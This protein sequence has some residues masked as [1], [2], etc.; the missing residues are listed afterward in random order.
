MQGAFF[1]RI[2]NKGGKPMTIIKLVTNDQQLTA[3]QKPKLASGDVESVK[4]QVEFDVFWDDFIAR[5]AVFHTAK[6]MTVYEALLTNNECI[7]PHEV[8]TE[9]GTLFIGIRGIASDGGAVKT[10][11]LIKYTITQGAEAGETTAEPTPDMYQQ[12][13]QAMDEKLDP[14]LENYRKYLNAKLEQQNRQVEAIIDEF[15]SDTIGTI[16]RHDSE[17]GRLFEGSKVVFSS[18]NGDGKCGESNP[19]VLQFESK[20]L[21]IAYEAGGSGYVILFRGKTGA[22][23]SNGYTAGVSVTWGDEGSVSIYSTI[24]AA[25]QLNNN[26]ENYYFAILEQERGEVE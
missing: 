5:S 22:N 9:P 21:V 3:S 23:G 19:T 26:G 15:S 13:L 7:I 4:V 1:M 17:I 6:H 24:G 20:P 2:N 25:Q 18:R 12:Y 14:Y 16:E 11:T 8:L 10:S